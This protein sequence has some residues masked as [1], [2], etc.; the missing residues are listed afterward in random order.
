MYTI[1]IIIFFLN[2]IYQT[3]GKKDKNKRKITSF[4]LSNEVRA[5]VSCLGFPNKR[6]NMVDCVRFKNPACPSASRSTVLQTQNSTLECQIK[7]QF[8]ESRPIDRQ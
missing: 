8:Q 5:L 3:T 7:P 1:I 2:E 6:L 4:N